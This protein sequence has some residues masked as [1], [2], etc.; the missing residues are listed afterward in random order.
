MA[1][2]SV[3]VGPNDQQHW[4]S[5]G[6]EGDPDQHDEWELVSPLGGVPSSGKKNGKNLKHCQSSPDLRHIHFDKEEEDRIDGEVG[7]VILENTSIISQ[8]DSSAVL[9]SAPASVASTV[10]KFSFRDAIMQNRDAAPG[11]SKEQTTVAPATEPRVRKTRPR[12]VVKPI[13]RCARSAPNL[14][15]LDEDDEDVLGDT[16]A[17]DYY[18][19]KAKGSMGRKNG[20][21]TRPDEAKR[22]EITMAKKNLQRERQARGK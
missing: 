13:K 3:D 7:G 9:V 8:D 4:P 21:K 18:A 14:L 22:L 5:L 12:F 20:L 17:G 6:P 1:S 10:S 11:N 15:A 16:D 2:P 19:Q